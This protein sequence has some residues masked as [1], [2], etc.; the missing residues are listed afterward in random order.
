MQK[1]NYKFK[2][3]FKDNLINI[4]EKLKTV[5]MYVYIFLSEKK[6][7][8]KISEEYNYVLNAYQIIPFTKR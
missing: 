6:N 1:T 3:C 2:Y 7:Q 8:I 4:T 5:Q